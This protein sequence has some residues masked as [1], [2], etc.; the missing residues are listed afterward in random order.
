VTAGF[1]YLAVL[2]A[3]GLAAGGRPNNLLVWVFSFLLGGMLMSGLVSGLAMMALRISRV[4]PRKGAVGDPLVIR[5][6]VENRSRWIPAFDIRIE[7][8]PPGARPEAGA[9]ESVAHAWVMHVGPRERAQG[10]MVLRPLRRGLLRLRVFEA[11]TTFPFGILRKRLLFTQPGEVLIQPEVRELRDDLL[12][13]VTAGGIGGHRLSRDPG[14]SD[15]F[16]GVREYRAGDSI[17]SIAW[18]RLAGTGELATIERSRSVPP[19]LRILV[20]LRTP[21][22][23]LR[24]A[25]GESARDLEER[26]IVLVASFAALAER[27]GYE[28]A[29]SVVGFD[30]PSIALRR[31][32]FHRERIMSMLA[33]IDLDGSRTKGSGLSA[34][35]ERATVLVVHPDRVDLSVA[36][37]AAWHF[38][39]RQFDVLVKAGASPGDER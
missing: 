16:F 27:L 8:A 24:V 38:T 6:E 21:T 19:R 10:E 7:E 1:V 39:A 15:D 12:A 18:K 13:R 33:S 23:E 3:V 17:R 2:L 30:F 32:Y 29:V 20:D 34:S 14:G 25:E 26:A 35:D 37:D 5:Y 36:P 22:G 31:G 11:S 4:E 9:V 28:H